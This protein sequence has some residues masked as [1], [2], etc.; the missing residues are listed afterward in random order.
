VTTPVDDQIRFIEAYHERQQLA[1]PNG[2]T[3]WIFHGSP[4]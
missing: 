2:S 4:A 1:A 3:T